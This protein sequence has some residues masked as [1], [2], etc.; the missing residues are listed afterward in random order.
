MKY[1]HSSGL[2]EILLNTMEEGL[3]LCVLGLWTFALIVLFK[4]QG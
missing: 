3:E 4:M 1:Q 2:L